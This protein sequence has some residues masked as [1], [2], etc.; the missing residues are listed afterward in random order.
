MSSDKAK[1]LKLTVDRGACIGS[2]LCVEIA[3]AHFKLDAAGQ[4]TVT[5]QPGPTEID[6][7]REA[8][9]TCPARA[10]SLEPDHS[11]E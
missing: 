8:V 5:R 7:V 9:E 6:V 11:A 10:I 1:P 2:G 3:P 4:S